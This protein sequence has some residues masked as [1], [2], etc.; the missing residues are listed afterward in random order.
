[1]LTQDAFSHQWP[2]QCLICH[3]W[4]AQTLC[5]LCVQRFDQPMSRC[6]GCAI[7]VPPGLARCGACLTEPPPLDACV[8]AFSYE[9]PWT[10]CVARLKFRQDVSLARTLARLMRNKP[11][12]A[13]LVGRAH[14]VLPVPSS[15]QRLRE[16]GYNPAHLLARALAGKRCRNDL[17]LRLGQPTSQR[18]L[19]RAERLE[20]PRGSFAV[21][22]AA[23]QQ[24]Q[25]RRIVLVDDVMTT[26]ATLHE[27]ARTVKNAGAIQ[28]S[29]L[30]LARDD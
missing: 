10:V 2:S 23:K 21:T 5:E 22:V 11:A 12:L 15:T 1:M 3:S 18:H 4:P 27:L 9:W 26:G 29:G 16:R 30:V 8:A 17:L 7:V 28:V 19:A 20:N 13:R 14:W 6:A 25:G 24:L